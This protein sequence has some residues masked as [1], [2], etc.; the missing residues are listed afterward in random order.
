MVGAGK[1]EFRAAG[2][3]AE[4]ADLQLIAVN[5]IMIQNIVLFKLPRIMDVVVINVSP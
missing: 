5:G 2:N 3:G 1:Q 4:F